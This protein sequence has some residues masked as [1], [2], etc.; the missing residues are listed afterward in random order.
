MFLIKFLFKFFFFLFLVLLVVVVGVV[1][2]MMWGGPRMIPS[3]VDDW[4][5]GKAG[6]S[7]TIKE[8]DIGYR[9]GTIRL[10]GVVVE[11][12]ASYQ[13]PRFISIG[14]TAV[15]VD[16]HSLFTKEIRVPS[17]S[18][19]VTDLAVV[20]SS[21]GGI[22][23]MAFKEGFSGK[24]VSGGGSSKADGGMFGRKTYVIES[25]VVEIGRIHLV[26]LPELE[27]L[28]KDFKFN[29][30]K[31][32]K[33]VR[34][35]RVVAEQIAED[36]KNF[37]LQSIIP[38]LADEFL[39]SRTGFALRV[40]GLKV[41]HRKGLVDVARVV[42]GNPAHYQDLRFVDIGSVHVQVDLN[43]LGGELRVPGAAVQ[44]MDLTAVR[45]DSGQINAME[46]KERLERKG[47]GSGTVTSAGGGSKPA[48]GLVKGDKGKGYLIE[49]LV[50][51][52]DRIH[53]VGVPDVASA[54]MDITVNYKKE[55][56]N[57][58]DFKVVANQIAED[59]KQY[60]V[61][62]LAQAILQEPIRMVTEK[63]EKIINE[64]TQETVDA[65]RDPKQAIEKV[66]RKLN[67]LKKGIKNVFDSL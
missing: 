53:V 67:E 66:P 15:E 49:N 44:F 50:V 46:F 4:L 47:K 64:A 51:E 32:F 20:Q 54:T 8:M 22:N 18:I 30:K 36:M 7:L 10:D 58:R 5:E 1:G 41:D 45:N 9:K 29:Y 26:G 63:A 43:S 52:I 42:V 61:M 27:S 25:L 24:K 11:N 23:V 34:D 40:E 16:W 28:P 31:E 62:I 19:N 14:S 12:P 21:G 3:V 55:F 35:L 59:M 65:I 17:A 37:A 6:F 57:V 33:N 39:V 48:S 56:K 2:L 13:D 60:G 38:G